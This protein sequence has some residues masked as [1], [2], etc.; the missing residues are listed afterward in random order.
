MIALTW[1][2]ASALVIPSPLASTILFSVTAFVGLM[3]PA[4]AFSDLRLYRVAA[5]ALAVTSFLGWRAK[6]QLDEDDAIE[7]VQQ[8]Q[9]QRALASRSRQ[10]E[11]A[12][13]QGLCFS[14]DAMN[15]PTADTCG[16]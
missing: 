9:D 1:I 13:G 16:T 6:R 14:C 8:Y 11:H 7:R 2:V 12:A 3:L 10:Q 5:V 4:G 15:T